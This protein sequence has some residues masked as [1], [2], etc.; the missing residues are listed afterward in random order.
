[1]KMDPAVIR[2]WASILEEVPEARL[3]LK[4]RDARDPAA[5]E[6]FQGYFAQHGV[7]AERLIFAPQMPSHAVHL[8]H[9]GEMDIALDPF[10]YN[11]TTTSCEALAMGVPLVVVA[12]ESHIARVG[13]ALN[14]QYGL[15]D[16]IAGSVDEYRRLAVAHAANPAALGVLRGQMRERLAG[17]ELGRPEVFVRKLEGAYRAMMERYFASRVAEGMGESKRDF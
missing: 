10:P 14:R 12:G 4:H 13:G 15:E 1:M 17:S 7:A 6:Q 11:G 16:W 9:Y 8:Q 5:L 3:L 2:L